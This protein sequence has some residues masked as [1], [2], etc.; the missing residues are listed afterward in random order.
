[1]RDYND[2]YHAGTAPWDTC[3]PQPVFVALGQSGAVQGRA[4]FWMWAAAPER[5]PS[6]SRRWGMR[7][8]ALTLRR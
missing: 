6:P 1:M 3:R 2:M 8:G 7:C 5:M 4:V